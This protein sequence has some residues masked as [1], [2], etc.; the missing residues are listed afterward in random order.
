[1][2]A[3]DCRGWPAT[4]SGRQP[5]HESM[6]TSP[7]SRRWLL[8]SAAAAALASLG[9]RS[10]G[11]SLP[12]VGIVFNNAPSADIAEYRYYKTFVRG[13]RERHLEPDRDL[14]LL[15]RSA[16]WAFEP[17]APHMARRLVVDVE[18]CSAAC[19]GLH[20]GVR[21]AASAELSLVVGRW[22]AAWPSSERAL[23]SDRSISQ[24]PWRRL[25]PRLSG[26]PPVGCACLRLPPMTT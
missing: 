19:H 8:R 10:H 24:P 21:V 23:V 4:H 3:H 18:P 26:H 6:S 5:L 11:A 20:A 14:V 12:R 1:M 17:H 7:I 15:P 9:Q 16:E 13:L 25:N 2:P 22:R